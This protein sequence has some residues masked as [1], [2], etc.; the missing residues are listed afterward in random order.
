MKRL[1]ILTAAAA[2]V[3]LAAPAAA[4]V[5]PP[6][7]LDDVRE[8]K[9]AICHVPGAG[10][11]ADFI[12]TGKGFGCENAGGLILVVSEKALKGHGLAD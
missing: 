3:I 6:I 7:D 2:A 12:I 11:D 9:V 8:G 4:G 10:H 5:A 1:P